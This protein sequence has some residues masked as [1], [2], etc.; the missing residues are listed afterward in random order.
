MLGAD[1]CD[2]TI[3]FVESKFVRNLQSNGAKWWQQHNIHSHRFYASMLN[4]QLTVQ[5]CGGSTSFI[6]LWFWTEYSLQAIRNK[7]KCMLLLFFFFFV[8][9]RPHAVSLVRRLKSKI[10]TWIQ[11]QM[12]WLPQNRAPYHQSLLLIERCYAISRKKSMHERKKRKSTE[13]ALIRENSR[14]AFS[15]PPIID[16]V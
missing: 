1:S 7:S 8:R 13:F 9:S 12:N 11:W 4:Y 16:G 5:S 2:S 14:M 6:W 3:C 15:L 10:Q